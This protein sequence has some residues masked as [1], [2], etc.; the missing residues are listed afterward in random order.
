MLASSPLP[1]EEVDMPSARLRASLTR[2]GMSG[3]GVE[4]IE[5]IELR[6]RPLPTHFKTKKGRGNGPRLFRESSCIG[7]I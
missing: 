6:A 1:W 4:S 5:S 7:E 3:E 2:Y